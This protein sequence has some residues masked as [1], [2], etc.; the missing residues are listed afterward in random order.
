M[1]EIAQ[2]KFETCNVFIAFEGADPS[3]TPLFPDKEGL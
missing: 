1:H 3:Q 2:I